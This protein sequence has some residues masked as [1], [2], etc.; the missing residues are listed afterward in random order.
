M[1]KLGS[2]ISHLEGEAPNYII[3][4]AESEWDNPVKVF[5]LLASRFG[6]G[7]NG[8]QVRQAFATRH[9]LEKEDWMQYLDALEGRRSQG[10]LDKW[11]T[12]KC[13]EVV[14]RF[15]ESIRDA[16]LWRE[17]SKF[18]ASEASMTVPSTLESLRF[19]TRQLQRQQPN[20]HRNLII[21]SMP[22][23]RGLIHLN[24][25]HRTRWC[26][27]KEYCPTSSEYCTSQPSGRINCRAP[28]AR[29]LL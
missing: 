7:G 22:W 12:T 6:T 28:A 11:I 10:L 5:E 19:T 9:R 14:Q 2:I 3:N 27:S 24:H 16:A 17:F 4:K 29:C 18:Y 1:I 20:N 23:G 15:I 8:M 25:Y 13:Y 26:C 21:P